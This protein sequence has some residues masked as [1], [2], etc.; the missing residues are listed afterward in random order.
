[1]DLEVALSASY[2]LVHALI[3][4]SSRPRGF[5]F[6]SSLSKFDRQAMNLE[7][8]LHFFCTFITLIKRKKKKT[9]QKKAPQNKQKQNKNEQVKDIIN[10][11]EGLK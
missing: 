1:M 6:S 4:S 10:T 5:L 9:K 2:T 11:T 3:H 8:R 7:L